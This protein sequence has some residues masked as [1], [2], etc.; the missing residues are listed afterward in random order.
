LC[1]FRTSIPLR[2]F[3]VAGIGGLLC[4]GKG[5]IF[6]CR[7]F[8]EFDHL[9]IHYFSPENSDELIS[10]LERADHLSKSTE[11]E[12]QEIKEKYCWEKQMGKLIERIEELRN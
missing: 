2:G 1:C 5:I 3:W 6:Q 11:I 12:I 9:N 7:G 4:R 10:L 8:K